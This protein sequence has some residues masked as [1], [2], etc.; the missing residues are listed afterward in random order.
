MRILIIE[1]NQ[2][3]RALLVERLGVR[4]IDADQ[5]A[6]LGDAAHLIASSHYDALL[7]DLG[8]PDGDG[9]NWLATL[10]KS[11]PPVLVLTARGTLHERVKGLDTGADD[12]LV[13]PAEAEEIAARLRAIMRRPGERERVRLSCNELILELAT[14][15]VWYGAVPIALG[16]K[17]LQMLEILL[18]NCGRVVPRERIE[19]AVYGA[20][21]AVTPN[22][23]EALGSRL[24]KRLS[25]A[26]A[27]NIL[28]AVRGV[29]YYLGQRT[30]A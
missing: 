10:P 22:A 25:E 5:A 30:V 18:R 4:G 27:E 19:A 17:E 14:R 7:L 16:R 13:K 2:A 23:L 8:L 9:L 29:G 20:D 6:G 21:E 11:R 28:H 15:E 3:L 26:G 24:R 12:Y 1:D